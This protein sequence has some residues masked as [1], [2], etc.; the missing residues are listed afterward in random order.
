MYM[1]RRLSKKEL[2]KYRETA[3]NGYIRV[4][5]TVQLCYENFG[6]KDG[7]YPE[8]YYYHKRF[9]GGINKARHKQS[10][11][12][13]HAFRNRRSARAWA[14]GGVNI[15]LG[16]FVKP[17]WVSAIGRYNTLDTLTTSKIIMPKYPERVV[18]IK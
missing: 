7:Y 5:K 3:K 18:K 6:V 11:K 10:D 4:W 17:S 12:Q 14:I 8:M 13:I 2:E 1:G 9:R 15:V 16:C